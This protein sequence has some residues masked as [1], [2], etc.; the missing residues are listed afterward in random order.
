MNTRTTPEAFYASA[1]VRLHEVEDAAI[2]TRVFGKGPAVVL[3]HGFPL[4]GYTWRKILPALAERF[5]CYV[6]DLPG[7]GDSG[8]TPDTDF[9]FTAQARRLALL[10]AALGLEECALVG[11][12]TGATL[13]RLAT[14]SQPGRVRKLAL[15][16]TEIPGHRPPWI[17]L[18]QR[19]AKLPGACASFRLAMRS[20]WFAR[21]SLGMGEFY[22]DRRLFDDPACLRPYLDPLAGSA[23]RMKGALGYLGG[24][25]W[26]A[27]DRL[28]EGH[29]RIEADTL[30]LWGEDD[31]TF[32]VALAQD[33]RGQLGGP[34]AFVRIA[35]ASLLPH[36]EKPGEILKHL[37]PFLARS[38]GIDCA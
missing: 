7:L 9:A 27:V 38:E 36:E 17:R 11:H 33:M 23:R 4:H 13:A 3:I 29:A 14:L 37:V 28:R 34:T 20:R 26:D 24:I 10:L 22:S 30:F 15:I 5:T 18:Y 32:P 31:R 6:V 1:A 25:D 8:W 16:N 19:M 35:N 21:S 2:A 12:D